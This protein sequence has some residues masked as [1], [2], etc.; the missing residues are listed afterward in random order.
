[1]INPSGGSLALVAALV[2]VVAVVVAALASEV[3][4]PWLLVC[5]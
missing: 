1:M 3:E 4:R 5:A 2:A